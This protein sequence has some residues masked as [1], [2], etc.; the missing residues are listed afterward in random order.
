MTV[1]AAGVRF[2]GLGRH[3]RG[4]V[5]LDERDGVGADHAGDSADVTARIVVAAARRVVVAFDVA[6]DLFSDT[7]AVAHLSDGQSG[8]SARL[9]ERPADAHVS[10]PLLELD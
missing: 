1:H 8:F 10:P 3:P 6:D 4:V 2:L 7:G 5:L 9:C